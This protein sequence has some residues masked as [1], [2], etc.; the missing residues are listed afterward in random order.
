MIRHF[1]QDKYVSS[2]N[3][4]REGRQAFHGYS[5]YISF[6]IPLATYITTSLRRHFE[7]TP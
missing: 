7:S 1:M 2:A 6:A 3:S 5:G 4:A